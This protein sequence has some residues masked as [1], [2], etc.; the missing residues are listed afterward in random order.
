MDLPTA[1]FITA[2]ELTEAKIVGQLPQ[3][4]TPETF[5]LLLDKGSSLTACVSQAVDALRDDGDAQ[6]AGEEVA[7]RRRRARP[8]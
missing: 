1:F 7:R 8:S 4:G 3:V 5:G 2:A 6:G